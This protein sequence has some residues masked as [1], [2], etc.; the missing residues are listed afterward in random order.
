MSRFRQE[1][2]CWIIHLIISKDKWK[3]GIKKFTL[4]I[5]PIICLIIYY[6]S[7]WDVNR[8]FLSV[9]K[10]YLHSYT[11]KIAKLIIE[12]YILYLKFCG[13]LFKWKW[14]FNELKKRRNGECIICE[15]VINC[16]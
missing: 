7:S 8:C 16:N 4:L 5:L 10:I 9:F 13:P 12:E 2:K 14:I 15:K 6:I 1:S 11:S 3:G